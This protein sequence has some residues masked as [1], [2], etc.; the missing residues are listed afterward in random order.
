MRFDLFYGV[1]AAK[2][3]S[4]TGRFVVESVIAGNGI[5]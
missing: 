2:V 4:D 3:A 1:V 5:A